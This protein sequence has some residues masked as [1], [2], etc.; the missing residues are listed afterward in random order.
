MKG[1]DIEA[2]REYMAYCGSLARVRAIETGVEHQAHTQAR[3]TRAGVRVEAL[4]DVAWAID[5]S[6]AER[7]RRSPRIVHRAGDVFVISSRDVAR[8]A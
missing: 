8:P 2:G 5:V 4:E 7:E 6:Q 3:I 1:A